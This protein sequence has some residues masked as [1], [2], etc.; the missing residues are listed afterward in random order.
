MPSYDNVQSGV[1]SGAA[2]VYHGSVSGLGAS[3]AWTAYGNLTGDWF[4]FSVSTAGDVNG[5]GYDE[6]VVGAYRYDN[7][8]QT[9]LGAAYV[10]YGSA[11]GLGTSPGWTAVGDQESA[12]FGRSVSTAGDVNGDGGADIII[13]MPAY[14]FID[15]PPGYTDQPDGRVE[16]YHGEV[17]KPNLVSSLNPAILPTIFLNDVEATSRVFNISN[18]GGG[19]L[20]VTTATVTGE[21]F[22]LLQPSAEDFPFSLTPAVSKQFEVGFDHILLSNPSTTGTFNG[23]L[24]ISSNGTESALTY[25]T[26]QVEVRTERRPASANDW[27][28]YR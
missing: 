8:Q 14:S 17:S 12:Q 23:M 6:V 27:L 26:L 15:G 28:L 25:V 3:P 10:Y 21:G 5:D 13:G 1:G 20:D 9:E 24:S 2:F 11:S 19:T 16:V 22:S 7:A 4:G 18:A